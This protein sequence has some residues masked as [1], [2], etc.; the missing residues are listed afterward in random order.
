MKL[1]YGLWVKAWS[2]RGLGI[3]MCDRWQLSSHL[4]ERCSPRMLHHLYIRPSEPQ[5]AECMSALALALLVLTFRRRSANNHV[6]YN[7]M[8][9][10]AWPTWRRRRLVVS[11]VYAGSTRLGLG[12]G[13][14]HEFD[15]HDVGN[16]VVSSQH[17]MLDLHT[18]YEVALWSWKLPVLAMSNG[19]A[20][21]REGR[22]M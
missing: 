3:E 14:T 7:G 17:P 15:V 9:S 5:R 19:V 11:E 8:K 18:T 1:R 13:Q 2:E 21:L 22:V 10:H 12:W 4:A 16:H 6:P 20:A